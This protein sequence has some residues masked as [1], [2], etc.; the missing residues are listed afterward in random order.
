MMETNGLRFRSPATS[1]CGVGSKR[2]NSQSLDEVS[3]TFKNGLRGYRP[4][5]PC[6]SVPGFVAHK[7]LY[8]TE[9]KAAK[10]ASHVILG[11][12]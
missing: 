4:A 12:I 9:S 1:A 5:Y 3:Y 8:V 11:I 6:P 10:G 2:D 7:L